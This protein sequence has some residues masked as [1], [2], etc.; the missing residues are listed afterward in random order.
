MVGG[1]S[2]RDRIVTTYRADAFERELRDRG[3]LDRYPGLCTR[4]QYGFP[5]GNMVPITETFTPDNHKAGIQHID[6]IQQYLQEQVELGHMTG[7]Y[8]K[9]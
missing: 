4:M 5:L 6:F 2:E 9:E 8:S 3:L 7:P 1:A